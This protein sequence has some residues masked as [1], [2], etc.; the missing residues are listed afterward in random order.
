MKAIL[1]KENAQ[2]F[3]VVDIEDKLDVLRELVGCHTID[4]TWRLI[5]DKHYN[6]VCNDEGLLQ[7]LTVTA[8]DPG[9]MSILAG[10]ILIV[11]DEDD[12]GAFTSLTDEDIKNVRENTFSVPVKDSSIL[13][14]SIS[15]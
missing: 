1:L 11:G 10:N 2:D 12:D 5:G 4:I 9:H 8:L 3:E 15:Y 13:L 6:I 7:G 14:L